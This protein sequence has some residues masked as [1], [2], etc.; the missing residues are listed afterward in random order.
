LQIRGLL[1][2]YFQL[3]TSMNLSPPHQHFQTW[4]FFVGTFLVSRIPQEI[5]LL[6][7]QLWINDLPN[8]TRSYPNYRSFG[9][10]ILFSFSI[11]WKWL[12]IAL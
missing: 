12:Y 5:E 6:R 4:H 7:F 8:L 10:S 2:P 3:T 9:P 1:F 11:F